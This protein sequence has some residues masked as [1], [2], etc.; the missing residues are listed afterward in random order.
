MKFYAVRTICR[1]CGKQKLVT[2]LDFGK[3]PP[4][5]AFLRVGDLNQ[6][7]ETFPLKVVFCSNCAMVQLKHVVDPALLFRHYFYTSSTSPVFVRHFVDLCRDTLRDLRFSRGSFVVDI[8]SND[9]ILLKPF[10]KHGM[11]ILGVEPAGNIARLARGNNIPTL[12][13]FFNEKLAI[14]IVK[15]NGAA[16]LVTATNVFAHIDDLDEVMRGVKVLLTDNGVF[17]VE[18]AY[19]GDLLTH[20][21]F[22]SVYH[23][24]V[25][26]WAV[27]PLVTF[28]RRYGMRVIDVIHV[29]T[30]GGSIRILA[31]K[32]SGTRTVSP[33]VTAWIKREKR[34]Q[35]HRFSTYRKLAQRVEKNKN[36]LVQLLVKLLGQ[37]ARIVGYGAPAKSTTLL[38]Y[39]GIDHN[40]LE[41]IVDDSA[42]KQGLYT[43]GTHIPV[44]PSEKLY[45]EKYD[46]LLILAWNFADAII[47]T[48]RRFQKQGG[49]FI[50]PIPRPHII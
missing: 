49:K 33:H 16:Q 40:M 38:H 32:S 45:Q 50:V 23:E 24:H 48:H 7:E 5:N 12:H 2:I 21:L 34:Q 20:N 36:Q 9:G 18:V 1:A 42:L 8:G 3:T 46:Y 10:A 44:V 30:H 27:S 37:G 4:A 14:S 29:P 13:S 39:F 35:L 43:P 41:F 22:D 47:K 26:Y 28:F 11:R 25:C 6:Q 31:Q 19:L 15:K 17:L